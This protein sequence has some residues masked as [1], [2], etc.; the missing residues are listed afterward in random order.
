MIRHLRDRGLLTTRWEDIT[1]SA[2]AAEVRVNAIKANEA[3]ANVLGGPP[4][5]IP[6][7]ISALLDPSRYDLTPMREWLRPLPPSTS[8]PPIPQE[9]PDGLV[10]RFQKGGGRYCYVAVRRGERWQTTANWGSINESM[11]WQDMAIRVR[12][13]EIATGSSP[14]QVDDTRVREHR[15]V[16]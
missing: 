12:K 1:D 4:V 9:P 3:T 16:V 2:V 10:L 15:A 8:E 7:L 5:T 13:F 11:R 6:P 14:V